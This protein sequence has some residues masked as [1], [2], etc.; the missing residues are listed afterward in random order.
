[1]MVVY[2]SMS[3]FDKKPNA[4]SL[5]KK[6]TEYNESI[7]KINSARNTVRNALKEFTKKRKTLRTELANKYTTAKYGTRLPTPPKT[8][9]KIRAK[10]VKLSPD[11]E[12]MLG[13]VPL[14]S[15]RKSPPL[16]VDLSLDLEKELEGI[17][18]KKLSPLDV[19]ASNR[20]KSSSLDLEKELGDIKT[21]GKRT[22]R[23]YKLTK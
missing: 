7:D 4:K 8:G 16:D 14:P 22:R 18:L 1:M 23:R 3:G 6:L 19:K 13:D 11:L 17:S 5:H 10:S 15:V 9:V 12:E 2:S 21:G 20:K